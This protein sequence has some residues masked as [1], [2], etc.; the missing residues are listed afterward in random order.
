MV[1]RPQY[2]DS[3]VRGRRGRSALTVSV[4]AATSLVLSLGGVLASAGPAAAKPKGTT[5]LIGTI[6]TQSGAPGQ[7]GRVTVATDILKAWTKW[8]N[9][10]GGINGHP[11]KLI[12]LNDNADPAQAHA[13]LTTLQN[14][15][16]LAIVGN[17]A[18]STE[19]TWGPFITANHLPV[20]G[21]TAYSAN[22]FT[23]PL[24][25]PA[26]T[27]VISNV[28]GEVYAAKKLQKHPK[29][30]S[31]LC[32][33]ATVCAGAQP[34]IAGAAK[35][36]GIPIVYN[37][38]ADASA[39]SYTPQCLAMKSSGANVIVPA[40]VNNV[41]LV[42]DCARQNYH[43]LIITENYDPLVSQITQNADLAGLVGPAPA[44]PPSE[45]FPQTK[46]YFDMLKKYAKGYL[47][48]GSQ[49]KTAPMQAATDA[50]V[51]AQ[52]FAKAVENAD[53]P[54]SG[55]FTRDDLIRGLSMF[56]NETLG[57]ISPPLTY[58]DGTQPNPQVKCFY[59]FKTVSTAAAYE[60]IPKGKLQTYCQP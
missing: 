49:Y 14:D 26:T 28:W 27:T 44:F 36:L 37:Q 12:A 7:T 50:Y 30:G 57:G 11:V 52:A 1:K 5:L 55:T 51:A 33:N 58:S 24:F 47:P 17:D 20:I 60:M 48:G 34:L 23:N 29:L 59:L 42:R 3:A 22:W 54:A 2:A 39:V 56:H 19:P 25:Y 45:Q 15:N 8:T 40:G 31:L 18:S 43:P 53:V 10:H 4:A 9:A 32:S 13:D 6:E 46:G 16:V 21:G 38:T 41:N 35:Q